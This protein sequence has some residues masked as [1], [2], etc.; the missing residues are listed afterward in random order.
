MT[1]QQKLAFWERVSTGDGCWVWTGGFFTQ[2]YGA[3]RADGKLKRA[4]RV[5]YELARGVMLTP[6]QFLHHTC[7]NKACVKPAH[8]EVTN[9]RDHVDSATYGN[10]DKTHCP[11]GHEYTQENIWWNKSGKSRECL[12]C[13]YARNLRYQRRRKATREQ[14]SREGW[15]RIARKYGLDLDAPPNP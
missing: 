5:A 2:G 6:D 3:I 4:H 1:I 12:T 8:M 15:Q 9:Q 11:H 10:K 7:R 13:K 14:A